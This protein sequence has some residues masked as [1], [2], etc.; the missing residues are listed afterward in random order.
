LRTRAAVELQSI[1]ILLI[2]AVDLNLAMVAFSQEKKTLLS[3]GAACMPFVLWQLIRSLSF[4]IDEEPYFFME[5]H[6]KALLIS[7]NCYSV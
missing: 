1:G 2:C 4:R 7:D 3:D 5:G 6:G